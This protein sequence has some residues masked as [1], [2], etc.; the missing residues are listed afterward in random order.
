[1]DIYYNAFQVVDLSK[2]HFNEDSSD[3]RNDEKPFVDEKPPNSY[4]PFN[5]LTEANLDKALPYIRPHLRFKS[6]VLVKLENAADG[7]TLQKA[8][9]FDAWMSRQQSSSEAPYLR[10]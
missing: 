8:E 10:R 3:R 4:V 5:V 7:I 6:N 9:I 1:V 2:E